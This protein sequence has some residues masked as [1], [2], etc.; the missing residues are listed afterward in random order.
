MTSLNPQC[1]YGRCRRTIRPG[2]VAVR[3]HPGELGAASTG[4]CSAWGYMHAE[5]VSVVNMALARVRDRVVTFDVSMRWP[6]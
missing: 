1:A 6:Q 5:H 2:Q 4:P 3:V